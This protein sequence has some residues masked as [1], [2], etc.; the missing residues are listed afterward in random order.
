MKG[1]SGAWGGALLALISTAANAQST[2]AGAPVPSLSVIEVQGQVAEQ[3]PDGSVRLSR[4]QLDERAIEDWDDMSRRGPAGVNFSRG[5]DSVNVRGMDR[6]RVMTRIDGIRL[7]WLTDGAR[8]EQGGLSAIDFRSLSSVDLVR[9]A[10]SA[11]SGS[12][13]GYLDLRT[14]EPDD[15][16]SQ[17]R[18]FGALLK[19]GYD[20]SDDA[21]DGHA[22]LAG[23]L[24]NE[25]TKWLIQAG[26]RR[27]HELENQGDVGGYG[28][29]RDQRNPETRRQHNLLLKLQHDLSAEHRLTVSG[30]TFRLRRDIDNRLE[31]GG[32]TSYLEGQNM[33][34]SALSRQRLWA[35]YSFRS[36]AEQAVVEYADL[37][38]YWQESELEGRQEAVRRPD[39]RGN[40]P[41]I[42]QRFGY[43][44]PYGPYGRDNFVKERSQGV[45]GEWGGTLA[46]AGLSHRWSMGG[47]LSM[48]TCCW[49]P[50]PLTGTPPGTVCTRWGSLPLRTVHGCVSTAPNWLRSGSSTPTGTAGEVWPG[51]GGATRTPTSTSTRLHRSKPLSAWVTGSSSGARKS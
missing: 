9:G 1:T 40:V 45:V 48:K 29:A 37:K 47:E 26:L 11:A 36:R 7:P 30:E 13:T 42:G 4:E 41:G 27:G 12:L 10:G 32:S 18:D 25:S 38:L 43:A 46:G 28:A 15:L 8:G 24:P 35:G 6:D 33:T 50:G 20:S 2:G 21:W 5:T 31:Q 34:F 17:G 44:Y 49:C 19:S 39:A 23:R 16:L 22:A 51:R 14:L 3:L